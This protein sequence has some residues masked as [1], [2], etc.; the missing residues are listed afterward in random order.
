[1]GELPKLL[2]LTNSLA[3]LCAHGAAEVRAGRY[4]AVRFELFNVE[5]AREVRQ[6]METKYP[7]V[8]YVREWIAGGADPRPDA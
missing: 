5:E 3:A 2:G 6:I 1:M 7:D 8:R 4:D